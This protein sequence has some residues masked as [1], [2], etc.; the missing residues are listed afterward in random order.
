MTQEQITYN[1][2]YI[3]RLAF[4]EIDEALER[5]WQESEMINT[6]VKIKGMRKCVKCGA[7]LNVKDVNRDRKRIYC[8]TCYKKIKKS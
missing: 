7:W 4:K 5:R 2:D 3:H 1:N 6:S 8:K